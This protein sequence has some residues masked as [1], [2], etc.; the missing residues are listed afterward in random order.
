MSDEKDTTFPCGNDP[1]SLLKR[2]DVTWSFLLLPWFKSLQDVNIECNK[3]TKTNEHSSKNSS[4]MSSP[5][6]I[7]WLNTLLTV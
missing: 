2:S 4:C 1:R 3:K 5:L 6:L 7:D